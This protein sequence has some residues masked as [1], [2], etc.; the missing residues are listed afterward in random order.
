VPVI[1]PR[2]T[3]RRSGTGTA[4]TAVRDNVF[5]F[6]S[7]V[8]LSVIATPPASA[9]DF[10]KGKTLTIIVGST[11]GGGFDAVARRAAAR[12]GDH[13]PGNPTVIVQNMPGA[14]S[15]TSVRY[16]GASA[17]KDGT[18]ITTFNPGL[19]TQAIVQPEKVG[20]DF[21]K[22]GWVGVVSPEFLVCYGFGPRG[23]KT[24]DDMM[25]RKEFILGATARGAGNYTAGA[26]LREV[27][28]A[29]VKMIIG[30]P[31][32]ADR[33]IAI[34]RGELDGDCSAIDIIPADWQRDG[35]AHVF[36]RFTE[37]LPPHVPDS[38]SY[39]GKFAK[40]EEQREMLD[41]I[42]ASDKLGRPFIVSKEVPADRLAIL[43]R[44]FEE[45]MKDESFRA[46]MAKQHLPVV[47]LSGT[48]AGEV[49][50]KLSSLPSATVAKAR[51]IYE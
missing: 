2:L 17:P 20:L 10:Y 15:L 28:Q 27:F 24:W 36:V 43:R 22:F 6:L 9:Q 48:A 40:T 31:G 11:P 30:F 26:A 16:L 41:L 3:Y 18:A 34:E 8:L 13:I 35:N 4:G 33:R 46:D 1:N 38:A 49:L 19:I 47:P 5:C 32:S 12:I 21:T 25:S 44:A 39:V 29:P 14:G 50:A 23:V 42:T 37:A 51:K 45:T 7:A